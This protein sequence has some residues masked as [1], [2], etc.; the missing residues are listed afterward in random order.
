MEKHVRN[1]CIA[2]IEGCTMTAVG[3]RHLLTCAQEESRSFHY[4]RSIAD[5]KLALQQTAFDAVICCLSGT[6]EV[7]IECL[8]TMG[9]IACRCPDMTRI[10]LANDE[11]EVA[12]IKHLSPTYIHGVLS[13][14]IILPDLQ[15]SMLELLREAALGNKCTEA[16]S[17]QIECRSLSPTESM[18]LRYMTYGYSLMEISQRLGRSIKT[19]RAHKFNAMT[20]LGVSSDAGLLSAADLLVSLPDRNNAFRRSLSLA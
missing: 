19:I 10:I 4:F 15:R 11:A 14:S 20:K 18:I 7:R 5:F 8:F 2:V 9:K 17:I 6:R 13:K 12:L 16:S 3:L 1:Q